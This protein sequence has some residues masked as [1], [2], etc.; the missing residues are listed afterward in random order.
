MPDDRTGQRT[1][2][3]I[4]LGSTLSGIAEMNQWLDS[5]SAGLGLSP[6]LAHDIKLCLNEAV[7]NILLHGFD[8]DQDGRLSVTLTVEPT[9]ITALIRDNGPA[10]NPLDAPDFVPAEDIASATIGGLGI[11]LMRDTSDRMD[12]RRDGGTN[13]LALS[14]GPR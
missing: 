11:K 12:Y 9:G 10:F 7:A 14:F 4:V 2:Q 5:L 8:G 1:A 13:E 6:R 3:T